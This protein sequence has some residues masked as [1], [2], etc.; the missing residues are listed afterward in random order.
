MAAD[1]EALGA[2]FRKFNSFTRIFLDMSLVGKHDVRIRD[3]LL[4]LQ[5]SER[6]EAILRT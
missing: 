6:L 4:A 5:V 2:A 1:K 3:A